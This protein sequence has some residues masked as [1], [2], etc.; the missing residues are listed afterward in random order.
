MPISIRFQAFGVKKK[1]LF[2]I[3]VVDRRKSPSS[4]SYVEQVKEKH[5]NKKDW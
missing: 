2:K 5:F 3:V 4:G 1:K